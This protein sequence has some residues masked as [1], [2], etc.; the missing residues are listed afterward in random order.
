MATLEPD[1]WQR[2][3]RAWRKDLRSS[4][5]LTRTSENQR[6]RAS[7]GRMMYEQYFGLTV[8]PFAVVPDPRFIF[9]TGAHTMAF[10]MLQY[11]IL[12][13][14]GF[15]VV[16]GEIGSGKTTLIRH[17]LS[18]LPGDVNIGLL[19]NTPSERGELL[20][21]VLMAFGQE[22]EGQSSVSLYKTFQ[23]VLDR[24]IRSRQANGTDNR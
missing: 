15:T 4:R 7:F 6:E 9:W 8:K 12:S 24:P 13:H 18:E 5:Y 14:A 1:R 2:W 16:T 21:W 10:A 3:T 23:Q 19:A 11:G 22:F 17:L 20:Q